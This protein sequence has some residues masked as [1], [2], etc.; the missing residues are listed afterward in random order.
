M[1]IKILNANL[2]QRASIIRLLIG[3]SAAL[4]IVNILSFG[5]IYKTVFRKDIVLI[6]AGFSKKSQIT[7]STMSASYI[8]QMA[9]MM[10]NQRLNVTP[11]NIDVE[12]ASI[13]QYVNPAYYADFKKQLDLDEATIKS[14]K[15]TS[16]FYI[17][18]VES[19]SQ[20]LIAKVTGTL[21][22]WVGDR[23]IASSQKVYDLKFS[24]HGYQLLLDSFVEINKD[25]ENA[26]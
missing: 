13:L 19:N 2:K 9:I 14:Q 24:R 7:N 17:S 25:K 4:V 6:P 16:A 21:K 20:D 3:L 26:R 15:I 22:R 18:D 10:V 8:D 11:D 5:V 1:D 12:N 23:Q